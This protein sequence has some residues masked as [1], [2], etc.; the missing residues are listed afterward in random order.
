MFGYTYL[1]IWKERSIKFEQNQVI[2]VTVYIILKQRNHYLTVNKFG[3]VWIKFLK[4]VSFF[5]SQFEKKKQELARIL[6]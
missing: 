1:E 6:N 2:E 3:F 5:I 4:Q